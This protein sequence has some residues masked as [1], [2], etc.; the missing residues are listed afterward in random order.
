MLTC[1]VKNIRYKEYQPHSTITRPILPTYATIRE[2]PHL[3]PQPAAYT[4]NPRNPPTSNQSPSLLRTLCAGWPSS[5]ASLHGAEARVCLASS[6]A[7]RVVGAVAGVMSRV[8]LL[9]AEPVLAVL[10]VDAAPVPCRCLRRL[11]AVVVELRRWHRRCRC[12]LLLHH[13]RRRRRRLQCAPA[14]PRSIPPRASRAIRA[15][16]SGI[17]SVS[18]RKIRLEQWAP[19]SVA[20]LVLGDHVASSTVHGYTSLGLSVPTR[21]QSSE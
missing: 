19:N 5:T 9:S 10:L 4:P 6:S 12:C 16:Y 2:P 11:R 8:H 18:W 1:T 13:L 7:S 17:I 14:S 15:L 3:D 21:E 20:M